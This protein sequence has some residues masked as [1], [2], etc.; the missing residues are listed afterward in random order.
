MNKEF[1]KD[2]MYRHFGGKLN[3]VVYQTQLYL[4][5]NPHSFN[6]YFEI[7]W[8]LLTLRERVFRVRTIQKLINEI[9]SEPWRDS[10]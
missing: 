7:E 6:S 1:I 9:K 4:E 8:E 2:C 5:F 10:E 3:L